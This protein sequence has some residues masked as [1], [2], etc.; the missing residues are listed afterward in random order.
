MS[1]NATKSTLGQPIA[2]R[3][4]SLPRSPMPMIP[5]RMRSFAPR[6]PLGEASVVARPEAIVLMNLR[7]ESM[8]SLVSV[9]RGAADRRLLCRF[10]GFLLLERVRRFVSEFLRKH[11]HQ[12]R[13]N[14]GA[15]PILVVAFDERPGRSSGAGLNQHFFHGILVCIPLLAVA[16]VLVG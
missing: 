11:L 12:P 2:W 5:A 16:P 15:R 7:R 8:E 1:A 10:A 13:K 3:V 9:Y 14:P 4:I 6:I